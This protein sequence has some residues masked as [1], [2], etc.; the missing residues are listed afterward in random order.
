MRVPRQLS[1]QAEA[2]INEL[3]RIGVNVTD[4]DIVLINAL[5][6]EIE[7]PS[8]RIELA[9]GRPI[10]VGGAWLWPRTI[11][12]CVWFENIGCNIGDGRDALAYAQAH[13]RDEDLEKAGREEVKAWRKNL[14]CTQD[15]LTLATY[16]IESQG[17]SDEM[18]KD[19]TGD[20]PSAGQL[21]V[22]M[23]SLHG[24][25]VAMWERYVSLGYVVDM[26]T[27]SAM[28]S[29]AEGKESNILKDRANIALAY[30]LHKIQKREKEQ[31]TDVD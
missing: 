12:A 3:R 21:V 27:T 13:G 8:H 22:L 4:A 29:S 14:T 17:D 1:N 6:W 25:D 7:K 2:E 10:Q 31:I 16:F 5:C 20:A 19:T 9:R 24:G 23:H 26:L 30:A 18:P 28:Q 15:E 11:A